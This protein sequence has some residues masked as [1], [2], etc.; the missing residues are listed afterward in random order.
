MPGG[1]TVP[2]GL[3]ANTRPSQDS[4]IPAF[5]E[6]WRTS[7]PLGTRSTINKILNCTPECGCPE[8]SVTAA[9]KGNRNHGMAIELVLR[10]LNPPGSV[11]PIPGIAVF[12][13]NTPFQ[14][15]A[16]PMSPLLAKIQDDLWNAGFL[17]ADGPDTHGGF[18]VTWLNWEAIRVDYVPTIPTR[19]TRFRP[20]EHRILL[21]RRARMIREL[22]LAGHRVH[23]FPVGP[24]DGSF[25]LRVLISPWA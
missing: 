17:P 9:C 18:Q 13:E 1:I 10:W 15:A 3:V 24:E 11:C 8:N 22:Q 14:V 23:G 20:E 6:A 12:T 2:L 21:G 25:Q 4:R 16:V 19:R 5:F 7:V